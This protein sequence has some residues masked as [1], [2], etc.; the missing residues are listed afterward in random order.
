ML[1]RRQVLLGVTALMGGGLL[2]T[3]ALALEKSL[4]ANEGGKTTILSA[5]QLKAVTTIADIIIPETDTSGAIGAGV[6]AFIDHALNAW[7]LEE[8]TQ[9]FLAALDDFLAA[10]PSFLP[11]K[12]SRQ[13]DLVAAIDEQLPALPY[14]VRFYRQLK[15]LVLVGYYTSEVGA[16][17][18]LA[19]DPVPGGY[20]IIPVTA[21]T[22]AW[23]T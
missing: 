2:S 3:S 4:T 11:A 20:T 9:A 13:H 17:E 19:Y 7:L 14:D 16:T 18:E 1:D 22:K 8:E 23:S 10:Y 5:N 15:E 6:P 21:E 12:A